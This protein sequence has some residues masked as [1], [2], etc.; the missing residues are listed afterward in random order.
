MENLAMALDPEKKSYTVADIE[1]LPEGDRAEL[2][3]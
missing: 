2:I 3:K 1:A